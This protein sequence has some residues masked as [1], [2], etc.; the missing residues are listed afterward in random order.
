MVAIVAALVGVIVYSLSGIGNYGQANACRSEKRRLNAAIRD[1]RAEV[2]RNPTTVRM[3]L[4]ES[5]T[6]KRYLDKAPTWY[7]RIGPD[8]VVR[9][10][11]PGLPCHDI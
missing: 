3:L 4:R 7:R 9:Q 10:P 6:G 8:G 11:G 1:Y 2:G 5:P